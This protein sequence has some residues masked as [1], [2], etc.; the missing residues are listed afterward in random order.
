MAYAHALTRFLDRCELHGLSLE[1]IEPVHVAAYIEQHP[2]SEPTVKQHLAAIRQL[3]D[4]L[5]V[6]QIV[7]TNPAA[8][9]RGPS[10]KVKRGKTP[11]LLAEET[12]QLLDSID[13]SHVVGLRDRALIAT[14]VYTLRASAPWSP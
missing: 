12:R 1:A 9:V 7:P 5:V 6:G 13:T 3:F 10:Y 14:M 11:L 8:A 2:A 4:W